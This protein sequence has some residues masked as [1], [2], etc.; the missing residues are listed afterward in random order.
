MKTLKILK[1]ISL[2]LALIVVVS[3][4]LF[5]SD[6][7]SAYVDKDTIRTVG[8]ISFALWAFCI[9]YTKEEYTRLYNRRDLEYEAASMTMDNQENIIKH[10]D[11]EVRELNDLAKEQHD[12]IVHFKIKCNKNEDFM[13]N[14]TDF[15]LQVERGGKL[16]AITDDNNIYYSFEV[17]KEGGI[18]VT[19]KDKNAPP[20]SNKTEKVSASVGIA[21]DGIVH[22][23]KDGTI[24]I[25]DP[26]NVMNQ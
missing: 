24:R 3:S 11:N 1:P 13:S 18:I 14:L 17:K 21:I 6:I 4:F 10:R 22:I 5:F 9:L 26:L 2:I 16:V 25:Y 7:L 23:F 12:R 8:Q 19:R 20:K 15:I